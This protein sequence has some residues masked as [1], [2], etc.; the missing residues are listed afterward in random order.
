MVKRRKYLE[1]LAGIGAIALA[2]C[3]GDSDDDGSGGDD[4][5]SGDDGGDDGSSDDGSGGDDGST[6]GTTTE[7]TGEEI[8][9]GASMSTSGNFGTNGVHVGNAYELW[10]QNVNE[11]GGLAGRDV[12]LELQDDRSE[13]ET[14]VTAVQRIIEQEDAD[15]ILGPYG[16]GHT[17]AVMGVVEEVGVPMVA[18]M[19][20]NPTI[21]TSDNDWSFM[22]Y[23]MAGTGWDPSAA[24][25]A[26]NGASTA[27]ILRT[28]VAVHEIE[29]DGLKE[30]L[31]SEGIE[32]ETWTNEFGAEDLSTQISEMRGYDPDVVYLITYGGTT[33]AAL[34]EII[35]REFS[36][37]ALS[38]VTTGGENVQ[39]TF[40]ANVNGIMGHSP[41]SSNVESEQ[42]ERLTEAYIREFGMNPTFHFALGYASGQAYEGAVE[43]TGSAEPEAVRDYLANNAVE[44][45]LAGRFKVNDRYQQVGYD[46][47]MSQW[48]AGEKEIL[49]P[50]DRATTDEV[51]W[52]KPEWGF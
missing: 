13:T 52:P 40:G 30:S 14:A 9:V 27:A 42:S 46:W 21:F 44:G 34:R 41:W 4:G 49:H 8:V 15:A 37:D 5:S 22:G 10:A 23:P 7:G 25:M 43:A 39:E 1:G 50:T 33:L 38:G 17:G 31:E 24:V 29:A 18:P 2:G 48:Q 26:E 45:T 35:N 19:A 6:D 36:P 12:R 51:I 3:S 47:L 11:N 28:E 16:S 20:S 32:H